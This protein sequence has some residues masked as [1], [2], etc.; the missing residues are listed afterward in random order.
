MTDAVMERVGFSRIF[1][2]PKNPLIRFEKEFEHG[3][4]NLNLINIFIG[5]NNSGKSTFMRMLLKSRFDKFDSYLL[6]VGKLKKEVSE[7]VSKG[8]THLNNTELN[9]TKKIDELEFYDLNFRL[10]LSQHI[11]ALKKSQNSAAILISEKL[12]KLSHTFKATETTSANGRQALDDEIQRCYIPSLRGMRPPE[13]SNTTS[14]PYFDRTKE[15]YGIEFK[16]VSHLDSKNNR[17]VFTGLGTYKILKEKLLGEPEERSQIKMYENFLSENFF[18]YE[19]V[20]LIPKLPG[21]TVNIKIGNEKQLPIYD[22]G[23]GIQQIIITTLP[24]FLSDSPTLF[25]IEEPDLFMH[26]GLQRALINAF[27]QNN[28]H[29]YFI[30]THSN[31]LLDIAFEKPEVISVLNVRKSLM[32]N[33]EK[34]NNQPS[35]NLSYLSDELGDLFSELGVRK[36]SV[37]TANCSVWVEGITDK[38]YLQKYMEIYLKYLKESNDEEENKKYEEYKKFKED[39]HYIFVEYA[40][41]NLAHFSFNEKEIDTGLIDVSKLAGKPFLIL[42]GDTKGKKRADKITESESINHHQLKCKEIEN[43]IPER[44]LI[45]VLKNILSSS[46]RKDVKNSKFNYD[47]ISYEKYSSYKKKGMGKYLD[48]L[49][50]EELEKSYF[51]SNTL[52]GR[53]KIRICREVVDEINDIEEC[54]TTEIGD[55]CSEIFLHIK[56]NNSL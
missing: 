48:E 47:Q 28:R 16:F 29:Q 55:M 30:T 39:F 42:D 27:I 13:L 32:D 45:R 50:E 12:D 51:G 40:G 20:T 24:M 26:P 22:L 25:F 52:N 1:F 11:H 36:T 43:L 44:P 33:R 19:E 3:I 6:P 23:D 37:L 46:V 8:S 17:T 54:L 15:D 31:H 53:F 7:I 4:D 10:Y 14:D 18:D 41:S 21:D 2:E 5:K 35:F 56:E 38:L 34:E 9:M 49:F